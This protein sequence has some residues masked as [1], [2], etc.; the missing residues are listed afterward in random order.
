ML[1]IRYKIVT[2][3]NAAQRTVKDTCQ[4]PDLRLHPSL[5]LRAPWDRYVQ[6]FDDV[7]VLA[8][9]RQAWLEADAI[10]LDPFLEREHA[11]VWMR[12]VDERVED[13]GGCEHAVRWRRVAGNRCVGG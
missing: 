12:D 5:S 6:L 8:T 2:Q 1:F 13:L 4:R 10:G 7:P 9:R 3:W 11:C